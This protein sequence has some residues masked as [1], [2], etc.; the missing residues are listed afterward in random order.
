MSARAID[1]RLPVLLIILD[2]LGDRP[3][4]ELDG[5]TPAEAAATPNLDKIA[6]LGGSGLHLP[7]GP[8]RAASSELAHWAMFGYEG[9]PFCG[10]AILE[11]RGWGLEV[12]RDLVYSYASVRTSE[13]RED[14]IWIT[15]RASDDDEDDARKLFQS[16]SSNEIEGFRFSLTHIFRGE[17]VL[18]IDGGASP[19]FTDTDP[20][21]EW[22]HP[23]MKP[24][25]LAESTDEQLS[26]ATCLALTSFLRK[27]H[28]ELKQHPINEARRSNGLP[29]LDV[30]TTK[31]TGRLRD[32]PSFEQI[33]GTR[34]TAITS[35]R[36][37]RGL[38]RTVGMV[39]TWLEPL[40]HH[41]TDMTA[42]LNAAATAISRGAQFVHVH[43][44]SPDE[45][46]HT[47]NPTAKLRV[48]ESIDSAFAALLHAPFNRSVIAITGDHA[49]P[50]RDG[51]LHTGDPTPIVMMAPTITA[52][53]IEFFADASAHRGA[54][55]TLRASDI[56]PVAYSHA[57]RPAFLGT[58]ISPY[59]SFGL[60]DSPVPMD[61]Q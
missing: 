32:V 23:W 4:P 2:G 8:G 3:L 20:L 6:R 51:V 21:F 48:L 37:Y 46:G 47:K 50:S 56:L 60:P 59:D 41:S 49:T 1:D 39:E 28:H 12:E 31:W 53:G 10:R 27:A 44:K 52:D 43:V 55:G 24:L 35:T 19:D 36:L 14:G 11:A 15:G 45:A 33:S 16:I 61:L 7:F 5:R 38:A 26:K 17:G 54:L 29:E 40:S 22:L 57:N 30:L 13:V 9:V 58:R 42:R 25:P 18:S 34:G